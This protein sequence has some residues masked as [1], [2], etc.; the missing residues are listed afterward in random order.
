MVRFMKRL[1]CK[2][3]KVTHYKADLVLV[4]GN[5]WTTQHYWRCKDC[6]KILCKSK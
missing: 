4:Y 6:G 5:R 3:K 1:L 2:H